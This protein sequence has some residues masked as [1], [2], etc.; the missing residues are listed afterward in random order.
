MAAILP[1]AAIGL[2]ILGTLS[3]AAGAKQSANA[4]AQAAQVNAQIARNNATVSRQQAQADSILQQ[5]ES[6]RKIGAIA[7]SY[8]ASGVELEGSPVE[9]LALSASD[10]ELDR[11]TIIYKGEVR[12][13]GYENDAAIQDKAASSAKSRGRQAASNILLGGLGRVVGMMPGSFGGSG[14]GYGASVMSS[15]SYVASGAWKY[16]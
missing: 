1:I 2:T 3:S 15:D 6:R 11:Q 12:A 4:E 13:V 7:A 10:A 14:G 16:A 8:G 5:R 9:I